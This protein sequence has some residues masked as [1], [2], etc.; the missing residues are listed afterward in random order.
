M[1]T[2]TTLSRQELKMLK[3][4]SEGKLYKEIAAETGISVNTVKKHLKNVYRKLSVSSRTEATNKYQEVSS[5]AFHQA[6]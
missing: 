1:E 3:A 5:Q 4:L 6:S 2:E